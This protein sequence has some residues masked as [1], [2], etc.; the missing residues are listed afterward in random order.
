MKKLYGKFLNWF[1]KTPFWK[2]IGKFCATH[3]L[4]F[5]G[6]PI[7]A[8]DD[9]FK[10]VDCLDSNKYYAFLST[11]T[12]TISSILIKGSVALT[13]KDIQYGLFSH[14]GLIIPGTDRTTK[15]MHVNHSGFQ[16]QSLLAHL[17][18]IDYLAIIELPV[19]ENCK[20]CI[21]ERIATIKSHAEQIVY[22]WECNLDTNDLVHIYCSEMLYFLFQDVINDPNFKPKLISGKL[23]FDPD[24]LIK[25][26]KLVYTNHPK[27]EI[28]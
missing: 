11:D 21:N 6:Y 23:Y 13:S 8:I 2:A 1:L 28:A 7:F 4:R 14:A 5:L 19:I 26:G 3:N 24:I 10:I 22:D 18:E 9:Y 17:K 25:V 16:Y 12:K 27:L 15:V 20:A